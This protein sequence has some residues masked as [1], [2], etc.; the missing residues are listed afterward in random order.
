MAGS[1]EAVGAEPWPELVADS[2]PKTS[3]EEVDS[4]LEQTT[5]RPFKQDRVKGSALTSMRLF[6]PMRLPGAGSSNG[7]LS[8]RARKTVT[9]AG[10]FHEWSGQKPTKRSFVKN[11]TRAR[12]NAARLEYTYET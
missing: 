11:E 2:R 12:V 8:K 7:M 10:L 3:G 4:P 1:A 5:R 9:A 6:Q